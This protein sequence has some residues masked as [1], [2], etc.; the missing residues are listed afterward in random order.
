MV[1]KIA[2]K[3]TSFKGA[4]AYYLHD[5]EADTDE[6]VEWTETRNIATGKPELAW[7]IMAATA[8]DQKRLK[9]NAGIKSTG[10]KS[11][12]VVM[13]YSLSWHPDEKEGLTKQEMLRAAN[14][15]LKAIGAE[16]HQAIIVCHNDEPH[17]HV[18]LMV[19]RVSPKDGRLL[20]SSK[21]KLNLS[22]WAQ[23][24]EE[25]RGKIWCEE[26]V[27]NNHA[28]EVLGEFTRA[29][30]DQPRHVHEE[31]AKAKRARE[32]APEEAKRLREAEKQKDTDLSK[33]GR[34]L[35]EF[36]KSQWNELSNAHKERKAKI[37]QGAKTAVEK[38]TVRIIER[39]RPKLEQMRAAHTK[40]RR[41]FLVKE[42]SLSGRV[43]NAIEAIRSI[44]ASPNNEKYNGKMRE[45]FEYLVSRSARAKR[46]KQVHNSERREFKINQNMQIRTA[47]AR[48]LKKSKERQALNLEKFYND[49]KSLKRAQSKEN[50]SLQKA[51][52]NRGKERKKAWRD[53]RLKHEFKRSAETERTKVK[54]R[55]P[56]HER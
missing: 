22:K 37:K 28:R 41:N 27:S 56:S 31:E 40:Q 26:R 3:G 10:R 13:T 38:T 6:R 29:A 42:A 7:R 52:L 8:L 51:W 9:D 19:N 15:S 16:K 48:I 49:R 33:R 45:A 20:P 21:E 25:K 44:S 17:P 34:D 4:A 5:K 39:N 2:A 36:H 46:V 32:K 18:H 43:R 54:N 12:N 55:G 47:K 14:D 30:K 24:Y 50:D 11:A 35:A 53:F 23:A 1:P